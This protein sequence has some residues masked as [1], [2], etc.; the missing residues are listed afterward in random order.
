M[1]HSQKREKLA[2]WNS[3]SVLKMNEYVSVWV[4]SPKL[5]LYTYEKKDWMNGSSNNRG[6]FFITFFVAI[7]SVSVASKSHILR[8]RHENVD[9]PVEILIK[10]NR[11]A[12]NIGIN[13]HHHP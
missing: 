5:K 10:Q 13:L 12:V 8:N 11:F 7:I 3:V 9:K 1:F 6:F 2:A 4:D